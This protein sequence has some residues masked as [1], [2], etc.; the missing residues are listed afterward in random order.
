MTVKTSVKKLRDDIHNFIEDDDFNNAVAALRE[1]LKAKHTVRQSRADGERG[2]EYTEKPCHTTRLNAAKLML[3][4]GFGKPATRA[5]ISIT[6]ETS[7]SASPAEI[8]ARIHSAGSQI[9]QIIEVY[10]ESVK[11]AP[12]EISN[13]E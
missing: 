7:K 3:E 2:V 11:D 5:E 10:A 8:M 4:Y 13:H 9:S 1:G 6:D 12:L